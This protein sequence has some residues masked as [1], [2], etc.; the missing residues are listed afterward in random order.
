MEAQ[1]QKC[2]TDLEGIIGQSL[3]SILG[4][5]EPDDS[6]EKRIAEEIA[7]DEAVRV[8]EELEKTMSL[9]AQGGSGEIENGC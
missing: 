2:I 3:A 8:K 6:E 5:V 9:K 4:P 1:Y 7:H